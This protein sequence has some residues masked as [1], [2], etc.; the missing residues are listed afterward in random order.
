MVKNLPPRREFS[1]AAGGRRVARGIERSSFRLKLAPSPTLLPTTNHREPDKRQTHSS[2]NLTATAAPPRRP[3]I[4]GGAL[5]P[6][7]LPPRPLPCNL[8]SLATLRDGREGVSCLPQRR[9]GGSSFL[10]FNPST[11]DDVVAS[12]LP[13]SPLSKRPLFRRQRH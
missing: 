4:P 9:G 8:P 7:I 13:R 12:T 1:A 3:T 5:S 10:D 6:P 11:D 2:H